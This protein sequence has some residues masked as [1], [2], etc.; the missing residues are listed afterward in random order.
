M[1]FAALDFAGMLLQLFSSF[2]GAVTSAFSSGSAVSEASTGSAAAKREPEAVSSS[3]TM[4]S[5]QTG[6]IAEH[7]ERRAPGRRAVIAPASSIDAVRI[8]QARAPGS[9]AATPDASALLAGG[10]SRAS[11]F[12][13]TTVNLCVET[14]MLT[15]MLRRVRFLVEIGCPAVLKKVDSAHITRWES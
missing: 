9:D 10:N 5:A 4:S 15:S 3:A 7:G 6:S 13:K 2:S 14:K 8:Q 11:Y 1:N 12:V